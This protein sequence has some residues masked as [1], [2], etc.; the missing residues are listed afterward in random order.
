VRHGE[1]VVMVVKE[2]AVVVVREVVVLV[3]TLGQNMVILAQPI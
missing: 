2:T 3:L 1:D